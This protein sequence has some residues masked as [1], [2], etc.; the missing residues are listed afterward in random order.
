MRPLWHFLATT[1]VRRGEAAGLRWENVDLERGSV[2]IVE[3]RVSVGYRVVE[4]AP[5]TDTGR[6]RVALDPDTV[7]VLRDWR[8]RQL[9]ERME[10][11][12]AWTDTG[13]VFTAE[14]GKP[15]HPDRIR[16][17]L[18]KAVAETDLPPIPPH[19]MR[20]YLGKCRLGS[21]SALE[22]G[23]GA[24][25]SFLPGDHRGYLLTRHRGHG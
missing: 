12:P 5:K 7:R 4:S 25:G 3:T 19:G 18:A 24:V 10:W 17:L 22:G 11:G 1:G 6:R 13:H 8:K 2:P 20:A 9:E 15:W 16:H 21:R 14:D 23:A